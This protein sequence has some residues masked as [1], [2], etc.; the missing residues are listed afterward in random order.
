MRRWIAVAC[1]M[2]VSCAS[3]GTPAGIS[4]GQDACAQCRMVI[5]SQATAAQIVSPGEEPR[6][7]DEIRCLTDYLLQA[8]A[9]SLPA[10]TAIYV[11]DHRSGEWVDAGHAIFTRTAITTPMASGVIA[12]ADAASRD[13]DPAAQGGAPM[14]ASEIL[15]SASGR[16]MP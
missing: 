2:T 9:S 3:G 15:G 16:V 14:A 4:R 13:A 11:A 10:D 6:F 12:H 5:V 7:F 8:S 1:L